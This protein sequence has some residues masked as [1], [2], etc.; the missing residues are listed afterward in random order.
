MPDGAARPRPSWADD[1]DGTL[2]EAF[3]LL[4]RG[5]ADRRSLFH[6][7]CLGSVDADGAPVLRTVV[8]RGF[9]P[10]ARTLRIHT[11]L[12]SGKAA[13][14]RARPAVALHGYDPSAQVQLRLSGIATV[15][16][17]DAVAE[18]AWAASRPFSRR[19][20]AIPDAPGTPCAA[21]PDA[22]T[23]EEAGRPHFAAVLIAFDRL[24]WLWLCAAGHRRARFTWGP[25]GARSATWLVP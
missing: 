9:D 19:C 21:P 14:L 2:A 16:A 13:D 8:L 15:H 11:D 12:R 25:D 3:R 24:E 22:P 23:D 17:E 1:L 7:P 6:T 10:A 20:Y 4:S 18:A 5:V